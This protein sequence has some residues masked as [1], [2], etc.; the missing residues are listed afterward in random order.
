EQRVAALRAG[1]DAVVTKPFDVDELVRL[2]LR[3]VRG[4]AG[5]DGRATDSSPDRPTTDSNRGPLL[6][7][8]DAGLA[9]WQDAEQYRHHLHR[10]VKEH[11][12]EAQ[13]AG[14][15]RNEDL[16]LLVHKTR[17]SAAALALVS[18]AEAANQL[19]AHL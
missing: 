12:D 8:F 17:G 4:V 3:L 7:D 1:M 2:L 13:H 5:G 19:E 11:E 18:V 10:F 9:L 16:I 15:L 14:M 6:V